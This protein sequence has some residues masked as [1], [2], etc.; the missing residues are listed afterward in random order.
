MSGKVELRLLDKE[1]RWIAQSL[2]TEHHY[3][4]APVDARCSVEGY[5]IYYDECFSGVLLF[6]RPRSTRCADWYGSVEDVQSGRCEVTRW[7]VLNLARVWIIP[8][9]QPGGAL[10]QYWGKH[11]NHYLPGFFDRKGVFRSTL[12]SEVLRAAVERI[13]FDYLLQRPPVFLDEPYE[14]KWLLS[15]CDTKLHKGTIYKAAGFELYR[16]NDAGIQTWRV[17]LPC[18]TP[19]QDR[20]VRQASETSKR[21]QKYRAQRAQL[22]LELW[23]AAG[24]R[25]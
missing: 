1:N 21:A 8:E 13:G 5:N 9:L 16:T 25:R 11:I 18:L 3:L 23:T 20:A 24:R 7:Q 22:Q 4:H 12:A 2:V 14:I 17:R 15:Y 10:W 19:E 6:G